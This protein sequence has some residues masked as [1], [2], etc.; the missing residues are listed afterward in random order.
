MAVKGWQQDKGAQ[1]QGP[2][3]QD[4][5]RAAMTMAE[6]NKPVVQMSK[7]SFCDTRALDRTSDDGKCGI[8]YRYAQYEK[9]NKERSKSKKCQT[10]D[11]DSRVCGIF[12]STTNHHR[13]RGKH[14][15]EKEC[16]TITHE[17]TSR[18]KVVR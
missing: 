18:M 17:N 5:H 12:R 3:P 7:I 14:E 4:E 15:P 2:G 13:L 6:A 9:W 8:E 11:V 16:T 10:R 1:Y